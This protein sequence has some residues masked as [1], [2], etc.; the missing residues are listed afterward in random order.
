MALPNGVSNVTYQRFYKNGFADSPDDL[1]VVSFI[2]N[3]ETVVIQFKFIE[4]C[5]KGYLNC[6]GT[7]KSSNNVFRLI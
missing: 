5:E 7:G 1:C 4:L 3:E 2:Y 6:T